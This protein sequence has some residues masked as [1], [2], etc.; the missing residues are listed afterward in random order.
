VPCPEL[1][2]LDEPFGGLDPV[3]AE[4]LREAV[5]DLRRQGTTVL[6]STHD[7]NAAETLCDFLC[8]IFE[9]RKV[10]DGTV[11]SIREQYGSDTIRLQVD[12]GAACLEG[13]PG[14]EAV[15]D[16]GRWQE[17]RVRQGQ[18]PQAIL[19]AVLSRTRVRSFELARPSLNDIFIR[20]ASPRG[21]EGGDA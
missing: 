17:L 2:I 3:H 16:L 13:L 8:M 19:R 18:D 1:L 4:A 21:K 5:L 10:L 7:M 9:G 12:G 11:A 6:F 20:I 15:T 14:V